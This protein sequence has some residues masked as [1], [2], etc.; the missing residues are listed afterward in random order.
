M[1]TVET[2]LQILSFG[3]I[4]VGLLHKIYIFSYRNFQYKN[5]TIG[6]ISRMSVITKSQM[7]TE[8][9]FKRD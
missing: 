3:V 5:R 7:M 1:S 2:Y 9:T 4:F 8:L 6:I